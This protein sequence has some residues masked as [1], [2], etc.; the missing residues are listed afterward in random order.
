[1]AGGPPASHPDMIEFRGELNLIN[2]RLDSSI[3]AL[4]SSVSALGAE[5]H[6]IRGLQEAGQALLLEK[7]QEVGSTSVQLRLLTESIREH[8]NLE[9][10]RQETTERHIG[11]LKDKEAH[12]RGERRGAA[13]VLTLL[14]A[15]VGWIYVADQD[16][17]EKKDDAQDRDIAANKA[18]IIAHE[19]KLDAVQ[20]KL[21]P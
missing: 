4:N 15:L 21:G 19:T 10:S 11:D 16:R 8:N 20:K 3:Q 5:V 7:M 2:Q 17:A 12:A 18:L 14:V 9:K 13:F 1:M 6:L